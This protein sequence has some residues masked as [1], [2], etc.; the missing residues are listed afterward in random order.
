MTQIDTGNEKVKKICDLIKTQTLDPA[1]EE[2]K[3]I[4]QHAKKDAEKIIAEAEEKA[5]QILEQV[6]IECESKRKLLESSLRLASKQAVS[7]LK[8]QITEDLFSKPFAQ[9]LKV[10]TSKPS[11]IAKAIEISLQS[12]F[13]NI[14]A[15]ELLLELPKT[16][17]PEQILQEL[18]GE[19]RERLKKAQIEM[20]AFQGG[21]VIHYNKEHIAIDLTDKAANQLLSRY[22]AE[23]MQQYLFYT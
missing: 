10:E 5:S 6:Q 1:K 18:S 4:V 3:K 16:V 8:Q 12:L 14:P 17:S 13:E 21:V 22:I 11:Y 20:G 23:P 2:A 7:S 19:V 15:E 9:F